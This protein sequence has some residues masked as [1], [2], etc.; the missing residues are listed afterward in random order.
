MHF[1]IV[2]DDAFPLTNYMMKPFPNRLQKGTPERA[3]NYRLSRARRIVENAF[4]RYGIG[5][6]SV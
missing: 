6:Q 1:V 5:R 4:G 3:F 2:A